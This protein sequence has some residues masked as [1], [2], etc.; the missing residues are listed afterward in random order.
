MKILAI[1]PGFER[2]GFAILEKQKGKE[3]LLDSGCIKTLS[4]SPFNE[5]LLTIGE[6]IEKVIKKWS[7]KILAI[8]TL[9]FNNNQKTAMKVSEARG[10]V[11]YISSKYKLSVYEYTPL[12]IKIAITGY[13]MASK[14]QVETMVKKLIDIKK[15][16]KYDDEM[17]AIAIGITNIASVPIYPQF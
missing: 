8:E 14:S 17:D 13:G 1:D 11:I 16:V 12:Q 4:S 2:L 5:R 9:F 6:E 3:V 7:P 10:V 15:V